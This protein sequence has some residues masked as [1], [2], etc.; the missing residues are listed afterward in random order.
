MEWSSTRKNGETMDW[1]SAFKVE[2]FEKFLD[3]A[4]KYEKTV[5]GIELHGLRCMKKHCCRYT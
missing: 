3:A 2:K 5:P 1:R 4:Y